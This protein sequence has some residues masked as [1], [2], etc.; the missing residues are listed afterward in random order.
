MSGSKQYGKRWTSRLAAL[1]EAQRGR[2]FHCGGAMMLT[3]ELEASR[4]PRAVGWSRDHVYPR[5]QNGRGLRNNIVLAHPTCNGHR[6]CQQPTDEELC[7][8]RAVY[9]LLGLVAFETEG[10]AAPRRERARKRQIMTVGHDVYPGM[11]SPMTAPVGD[12]A[13][14]LCAA[15]LAHRTD[16]QS[17]K[18]G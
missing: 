18:G 3:P 11:F 7:R 5:G 1:Y 12:F 9:G 13:R 4:A 10:Q 6:G 2:C 16:H 14:I 8:V 15:P 17:R